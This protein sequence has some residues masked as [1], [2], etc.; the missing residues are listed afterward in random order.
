MQIEIVHFSTD[1][2]SIGEV[3]CA[4]AKTLNAVVVIMASHNK[5]RNAN[6]PA[7]LHS[8]LRALSNSL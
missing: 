7:V 8:L 6:V 4:R 5:V 1:N 3:L 2:D